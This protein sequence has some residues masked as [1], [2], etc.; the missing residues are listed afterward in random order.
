MLYI[1]LDTSHLKEER[2]HIQEEI[3]GRHLAVIFDGTSYLGETLAI[4]LRYVRDKWT[5]E[6]YLI[7]LQLLAKSL[8][9]EEIA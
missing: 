5:M 7:Q 4:V 9:G 1:E 3:A 6:Q 8:N 2:S